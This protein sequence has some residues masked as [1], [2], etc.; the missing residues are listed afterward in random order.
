MLP[1]LDET[2][3]LFNYWILRALLIIV[4]YLA[5]RSTYVREDRPNAQGAVLVIENNLR[6][7]N[8]IPQ[9]SVTTIILRSSSQQSN[10][11]NVTETEELDLEND[12]IA[13]SIDNITQSILTEASESAT[14]LDL[15]DTEGYPSPHVVV[16]TFDDTG[17]E[18]IIRQMDAGDQESSAGEVPIELES[19]TSAELR[20]RKTGNKGQN[21]PNRTNSTENTNVGALGS[22]SKASSSTGTMSAVVKPIRIKLK[23]L[24]DDSKLV[25]GNL[26]EGIGE[27]KQRNFTV[28][29]GAQKLVRLVFNGHVLQPDTKTLA[30]CGLFDNC[31]V[32]CLIHNQKSSLNGGDRPTNGTSN[33]DHRSQSSNGNLSESGDGHDGITAD[34]RDSNGHPT[35]NT[36]SGTRYGTYFIYIGTLAVTAVILYG[37]YCRFH[38]GHLFNLNSTIG[39]IVTTTTF[40]IMMPTIILADSNTPN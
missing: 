24:N 6:R 5:W 13:S 33:G 29:L 34:G 22:T 39:L 37:W 3:E 16:D 32:H 26:N 19:S 4:V 36:R 35:N 23:Y 21:E 28:E 18:E 14:G 2:D 11:S 31:V 7:L 38:Y 17:P 1:F 27:F 12:S 30:A 10:I 25:E 40:L 15:S 8:T 20:Q 9:H